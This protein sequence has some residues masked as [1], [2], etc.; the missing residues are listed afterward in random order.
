MSRPPIFAFRSTN[1]AGLIAPRLQRLEPVL[2]AGVAERQAGEAVAAA[3]SIGDHALS[4]R[5][6]NMLIM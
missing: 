2:D 4:G 1:W 5:G 6:P 3:F